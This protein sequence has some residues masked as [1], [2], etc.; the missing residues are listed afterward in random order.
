MGI[1]TEAEVARCSVW[2]GTARDPRQY[3]GVCIK[4]S[5]WPIAILGWP[6]M[7]TWRIV[8][9][10]DRIPIYKIGNGQPNDEQPAYGS[11]VKQMTWGRALLGM[12]RN[13]SRSRS[14]LTP[15]HIGDPDH[16]RAVTIGHG[17]RHHGPVRCQLAAGIHRLAVH[18]KPVYCVSQS[19]NVTH[20]V[21]I[22]TV[23]ARW[24]ENRSMKRCITC[25]RRVA[26]HLID[27]FGHCAVCQES[28][29]AERRAT[30]QRHA[31]IL[32]RR[33][34]ALIAELR[35]RSDVLLLRTSPLSHLDDHDL[36]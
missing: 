34:S 24:P 18:H 13:T 4:T 12:A 3:H 16:W 10:A 36:D 14:H 26:W 22:D 23:T 7:A 28:M 17:G 27:Y 15:F 1:S 30:A 11:I 2:P 6:R 9:N 5:T 32:Q 33:T 25:G 8:R 19:H 31:A 21:V 35:E 29:L 20:S